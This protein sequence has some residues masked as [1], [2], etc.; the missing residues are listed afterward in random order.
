MTVTVLPYKKPSS[1]P[2]RTAA[3][4]ECM[5]I[6]LAQEAEEKSEC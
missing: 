4:S 1:A 5:K 6:K 2:L 3:L